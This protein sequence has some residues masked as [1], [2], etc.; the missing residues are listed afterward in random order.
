[1]ALFHLVALGLAC[2][3]TTAAVDAVS[4]VMNDTDTCGNK[5]VT[6]RSNVLIQ[7]HGT[8]VHT[9]VDACDESLWP[10]KDHG[11]V[12][13]DCKVL[14]D[15]FNSFYRTCS[16]YCSTIGREC[17]G[18]WE[19]DN[20]NCDVK[21][22]LKCDEAIDS[23]DAI[24]ECGAEVSVTLPTSTCWGEFDHVVENEGVG[25]G[26]KVSTSSADECKKSCDGNDQ[27]N[28]FTLCPEWNGCWMKD[29]ALTGGEATKR[30]GA[31]KSFYKTACSQS[32]MNGSPAPT[33]ANVA[34]S[35]QT[36]GSTCYGEFSSLVA[37]EGAGI[38]GI[39]TSSVVE[40]KAS[41]S[42]NAECK[43]I[44]FCPQWNGCWMK[45]RVLTGGEATKVVGSC[46]TY[47]KNSC[48][49]GATPTVAPAGS[50]GKIKVVS[51]NIFWW[52]AFGQNPWK[53]E[54]VTDNIKNTLQ[55]DVLG[56]QECDSP[57]LIQERTGYVAASEFAGA[58][59][60]VVKPGLFKIGQRGRQDIQA[61]GKWGPR[62]V[63]FVQLTHP[64]GRTFWHFNTHWCVHS[65]NGQTCDPNKRYIGAQNM[66]GVIHDKAQG[67]PVIITG[68]FN[69][70]MGEPGPQHFSK[71][72]FKMIANAWVDAI[73]VSEGHWKVGNT[74]TGDAAHSDHRPV[75][76][77][78]EFA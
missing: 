61:T 75:F 45:D 59:G 17:A 22:A 1:M 65:G 25:V 76:A 62:Y 8:V 56:L 39:S 51:Y 43:S 21:H 10:D 24:C 73:F 18:A 78:L 15:R 29:R 64:S 13:G 27:C 9:G 28:S 16:G 60:V 33:P 37:D 19:E 7:R 2:I 35:G 77:E 47:F 72:G 40:C 74:G 71:N 32:E 14:V 4:M 41:C 55:P 58:Q 23:S 54:H 49:G 70:G 53:G 34:P 20:D 68:D 42:R 6:T 36:S 11:L 26:L 67:A 63:T 31:C 5:D 12:C 69:A 50:G 52:N 66:L 48:V 30:N 38:G 44:S 57:Q 46:Q 3:S